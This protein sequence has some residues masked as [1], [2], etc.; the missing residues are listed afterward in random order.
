MINKPP[1]FKDLKVRIPIATPVKGSGFV[2]HGSG[3]GF[4]L[5][6]LGLMFTVWALGLM[7]FRV[8]QVRCGTWWVHVGPSK[9]SHVRILGPKKV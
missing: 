7:G 5:Y 6:G 9:A 4:G 3:L 1:P 2:N 8:F